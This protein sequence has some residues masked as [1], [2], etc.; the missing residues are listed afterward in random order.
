MNASVIERLIIGI[1]DLSPKAF[2][3]VCGIEA[4]LLSSF[5]D[6][7]AVLAL[8]AACSARRAITRRRRR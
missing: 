8:S 2:G 3:T 6:N 1:R 4:V 7:P 5:P